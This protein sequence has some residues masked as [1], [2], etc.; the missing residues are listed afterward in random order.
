MLTVSHRVVL[1]R[2]ANNWFQV[3]NTH[4]SRLSLGDAVIH[5]LETKLGCGRVKNIDL[6]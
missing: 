3:G 2:D 4:T 5:D 1:S 6:T